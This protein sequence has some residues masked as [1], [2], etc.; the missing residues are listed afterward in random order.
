MNISEL[1]RRLRVNAEE[2]R[3]HLPELGFDVGS[4]AIKIEDSLAGRIIRA[5]REYQDR[6]KQKAAYEKITKKD[7]LGNIVKDKKVDIP[8]VLT[9]RDFATLLNV[10]LNIV[11]TELM[12]NGIMASLNQRIDFD[13]AAI[14]AGELGF[15]ATEISME[16][17][18]ELDKAKRMADKMSLEKKEDMQIRPPIVVVMGHVDHGKT[19]LLDAIRKTNVMGGEAGG[20]TQH[21]GAY[22]VEIKG[23]K[24][25][26][27][28]TPGHE[29]FTAMR[30]RGAKVADIA[31]LVVAA[32]EGVMPQTVE[33]LK[34][35][36]EAGIPILV[37]LNKI[38][39]PE[40]NPEK[41]KQELAKHDLLAEEWGGKTIFVEISAKFGKNIDKLLE[42]VLLMAEMNSDT[43]RSNPNG[44]FFGS[45]IESH[46][47]KGAGPVATVLVR[48]GTLHLHDYIV[49]DGVLY[50]RIKTMRDHL[51]AEQE[52]SL[53]AQP[54]EVW[55]LKIAPKVGD[56]LEVTDDP[57]KAKR[58]KV[59][60]MQ[61]DETFIKQKS[62]DA[63]EAPAEGVTKLNIVLRTDV[64]GS[65]EAIF[66]SLKKF[67]SEKV[68]IEII[69]K[70]LGAVTES[71]VLSAEAT[72][73]VVLGFNVLPSLSASRLARDKKVDVK[74]YKIIYELLDEV[75]KRLKS[76]IKPTIVRRD[77]GKMEV[78]AIFKKANDYEV[79][80]GR[81]NKGKVEPGAKVAVLRGNEFVTS[82]K[83]TELQIGK[84]AV[85]DAVHSQECGVKFVGQP[86]IEVGDI[87]DVYKEEEK[88]LNI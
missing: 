44:E 39:L 73:A 40:S 57:K 5:W 85:K 80:G 47:D 45:V 4:K 15:E 54:V 17:K 8:S 76:L 56:I 14:V 68:K 53:P 74:I 31:I 10:P 87:L 81:V 69:S 82:G 60:R 11:I 86:L 41:T 84:Q 72:G 63:G 61:Q 48:N 26:F 77:L 67:E 30:S 24:I 42:N 6:L 18:V 38:D 46:V 64:L 28:D 75:K 62:G 49:I 79:V 34:I 3:Q 27:I 1:A 66:E 16:Q 58:T 51:G 22:Q 9:V 19:K 70:G 29:A 25:T 65:Q 36:K 43:L 88:Y 52:K 13:T 83:I 78:L 71:D 37:A 20:I 50:G 12:K 59:Y 23:K 7:E 55:G 2:L 32:T 33:A 21:I 35:A